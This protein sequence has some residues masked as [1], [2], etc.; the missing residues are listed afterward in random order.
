MEDTAADVILTAAEIAT[1]EEEEDTAATTG[2][3]V[4]AAMTGTAEVATT[5]TVAAMSPPLAVVVPPARPRLAATAGPAPLA[6]TTEFLPLVRPLVIAMS[7][8]LSSA[9]S[10][11]HRNGE[12]GI[13]VGASA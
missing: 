3:A 2:T 8:E 4:E 6:T 12:R 7:G 10:L 1:A 5:A 11:D 13:S 9:Q